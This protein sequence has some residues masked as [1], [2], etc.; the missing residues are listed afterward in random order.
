MPPEVVRAIQQYAL[1][2]MRPLPLLFLAALGTFASAQDPQLQ[3]LQPPEAKDYGQ[4]ESLRGSGT[5]S[6]DGLWLSY[7]V[8]RANDKNE[9]RLADIGKNRIERRLPHGG[10]G[11]IH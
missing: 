7:N 8:S 10:H 5:L 1:G 11:L 3:Q 9:L 2:A 4:W 6:P